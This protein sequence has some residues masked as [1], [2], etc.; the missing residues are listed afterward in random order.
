MNVRERHFQNLARR[1]ERRRVSRLH[2]RMSPKAWSCSTRSISIQA[3]A[4]ERPGL[5]L[6]LQGRQV[7]FV[8]GRSERHAEADV[9]D[10]DERSAARQADHDRADEGVSG[11]QGFDHGCVVEFSGEEKDQDI[12][13]APAGCAGRHLANAAG[14]HRSRAGISEMHRMFSL[15]GC[16]PRPARSSEARRI[17]RAALSDLHRRARRC[18]RSIPRIGSRNCERRTGIGYCNITKC[19][20]KVCPENI[21][22]TDNGI[23]PLKERVVDEFYDPLRLDLGEVERAIKIERLRL[24]SDSLPVSTI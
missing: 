1:R 11:A 23:I 9:H 2:D 20:T 16:L 13:A 5:P 22:I 21:Q 19:C 14:R 8:F 10:A 17:H 15:P 12:Q 24:S 6:E 4:G 18:I 3:D 7:R